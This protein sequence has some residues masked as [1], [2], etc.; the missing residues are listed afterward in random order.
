MG[1][2]LRALREEV[3]SRE[4]GAARKEWGGRTR[5]ALVY[6]NR[7]AT[8][9]S[10]LG[11]L[12]VH[13]RINARADALCERAFLPGPAEGRLLRGRKLPLSALES[14][15]PLSDFDVVA[16]SLSYENDLLNVPPI[17]A[18]GGVPALRHLRRGGG[19]PR[20][21]V[22]A[23]GFAA[24]LNPEPAGTIADAV[25][26]GDGER[27]VDAILSLGSP[28]PDDPGYLAE[29]AAVPGVYVPW[30]YEPEYAGRGDG[31][32]LVGLTPRRGFPGVVVREE[33]PL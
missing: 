6:P 14:G 21:L 9:M 12:T 10:N 4:V 22:L 2:E 3:L 25:V 28:R 31:R 1:R 13:A 11:F 33:V 7:Y 24:S 8:G 20:P 16:F 17:L 19:R 32:T 27:A 23:G 29:L 30:G 26:V 5:V 18:A 15:R